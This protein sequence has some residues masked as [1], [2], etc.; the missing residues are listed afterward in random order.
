MNEFDV[1]R[2]NK[3]FS[4]E[5][6]QIIEK[7]VRKSKCYSAKDFKNFFRVRI[8]NENESGLGTNV[9]NNAGYAIRC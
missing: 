3:F 8:R 1:V 4:R 6:A 2:V 9:I 5:I 7:V